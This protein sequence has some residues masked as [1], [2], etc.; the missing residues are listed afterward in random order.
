MA[1]ATWTGLDCGSFAPLA[2]TSVGEA[3]ALDAE[4]EPM[5]PSTGMLLGRGMLAP[6]AAPVMPAKSD[7]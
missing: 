2:M 1:S 7:S 6:L 4:S 5:V 3:R